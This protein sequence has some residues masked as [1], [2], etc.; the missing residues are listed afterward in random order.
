MPALKDRPKIFIAYRRDDSAGHA[1]RL[2]DRL[3]SHFGPDRIFMDIDTIQPGEDFV[4]VL[5]RA[6][7]SCEVLVAI[8]GRYWL[9]SS[10]EVGRRIERPDDFVRVELLTAL[11]RGIPIIPVLVHGASMPKPDEL[12]DEL[13]PL[14][15]RQAI[16]LS[17]T[18]WAYDVSKL[19]NV[20][21]L[22]L[23]RVP[24]ASPVAG[25]SKNYKAAVSFKTRHLIVNLG[26]TFRGVMPAKKRMWI[27]AALAAIVVAILLVVIKMV[28]VPVVDPVNSNLNAPQESVVTNTPNVNSP[29]RP[30]SFPPHLEWAV[31]ATRQNAE[32]RRV[33]IQD[34]KKILREMGLYSGPADDS[35]DIPFIEAIQKFQ[36]SHG[37]KPD[38][39]LGLMTYRE[40]KAA[41]R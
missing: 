17:D 13:E 36:G 12:P 38:G 27:S 31:K 16:E 33:D 23:R 30:H 21:E 5:E 1:G 18:R 14:A 7:S 32:S 15:R 22:T 6:V 24:G 35:I 2:Y 28:N 25:L 26:K 3:Y 34:A 37:L 20:L 4:S 29:A 8:I 11:S 41:G 40:L 39:A 10:D 19:I 9:S